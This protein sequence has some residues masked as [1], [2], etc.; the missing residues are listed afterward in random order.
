M[1]RVRV[2]RMNRDRMN[3]VTTSRGGISACSGPPNILVLYRSII[4]DFHPAEDAV[5]KTCAMRPCSSHVLVPL[6]A[7]S[8][9]AGTVLAGS[10]AL[11]PYDR[12]VA[13]NVAKLD[14]DPAKQR[15]G[16]AEALGFLRAYA[17]EQALVDRLDDPSVE[18]RRQVAMAL[19]WCGGRSAIPPLLA[20]LDDP[21]WITRQAARVSL[22]NLTGME[23]PLDAHAPPERRAAQ[24]E[25]WRG[26]WASVPAD[27]PPQDVLSLLIGPKNLASGRSVIAST[28]YK[29]PA[30]VLVDGQIGPAYWQTKN[31]EP[32]QWCIVDLGRPLQ[33]AE[34]IVHQYGPGYCMTEYELA[35]SLDNQTFEPVEHKKGTTPVALSIRFEPRKARY[36]RITS[37]G[38]EFDRY[39]TTFFE[40]EIKSE[41]EAAE[42]KFTEPVEW[43]MERGV[44]ALGVLGGD[45]ATPAILEVLGD[46]PPTAPAYRPMVRAAIRSLGR[47]REEAGFQALVALLENTMWARSAAEALGD[48][49]DARA[50]PALLAVY[51]KYA[52]QLDGQDPP[53]VPADD[54]MSF[55]SEDRMLETPYWIEYTLCRLPL[56]DPDHLKAL[57]RIAPLVMANMQGDHDTFMLYEPEVGHLVTHHLLQAC[58]LRQE[59]CEQA[60]EM[61]GQPRRVPKPDDELQWPVF[62]AYRVA[63]WLPAVATE[64]EDLPRL[65]ALLE[66]EEGWVRINAAKALAWLG[67]SRAIEP[68]G[69]LLA[70]AKAEADFGYSGTFKDEEYNDPAP[71]WREGLIRALGL[72]GAH[73][74]TDR[75]IAIL[76][77]ER[78]VLDVR[79]AA[80]EALVDLG[81]EKALEA[82]ENAAFDHSFRSIRL[83]AR[84]ALQVRGIPIKPRPLAADDRIEPLPG[85]TSP[86]AQQEMET[87]VFIKGNNSIPNTLGTV[88]QAD[89]WRATYVVTDSGPAYRP[90]GNLY[91][92]KPPRPDGQ[93]I[94]LTHFPDGYVAEPELSWDGTHVLFC[95]RGQDD[96]W[97][98]V[99]RIRVDSSGLEQLTFG[100]YHDVGPA[101]LAD[102]RIVFASSRGG[103]RD[104]YHGYPATALYVMQP[105]GTGMHPIATNI[106]RDNEPAILNDGRIVISRLE[107][108]YS[109]NKTELTLHA[110]HSDGTQ[111][112][113]LYG[114]ERRAYWRN[115]DHGLPSPADAQEAP[116]THRVLRMTQP[117]PM[118]DRRGIVVVTE[119]GLVLVGPKRDTETI[120]TPDYKERSYTTPFPLPGGR[121]LCASTL[122]VEEREKVDLGLYLLDPE[123]GNLELVYNDPAV[124][125]FEP[126]PIL[127]RRR[128]MLQPAGTQEEA[129]SGRFLCSSVFAT[130]EKDVPVRGRFVRLIEGVPVVA[131]HNTHT[132]DW[133]VWKNHGG[134]FARVLGT[135]P[136]APDGSFYVEVPADRL[137]HHQVLDSDRRVVGNQL[138]WIYP[139]PGET[140]SCVGCHENPHTTTRGND[141]IAT[142]YPPLSFLPS[143]NEFTYRA[144]A[145]FK[146]HLPPEID[147]RTRTV[148]AVN[149]LGR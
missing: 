69:R 139:R 101:Y 40:I 82:L 111:D 113:V 47:L 49:G 67:D 16:A 28:T 71:R 130:Q 39:P 104:E 143:G 60:L 99:Y 8:F 4:Y 129:Y 30:D 6:S 50:V 56:D 55:P 38:S 92:L 121:I 66:H 132:S 42:V 96:P 65:V 62:P 84:D 59:A 137:I 77:D 102:G 36:V 11:R 119:G 68:L 54:K 114:P 76:N 23:F 25:A 94:P 100:P 133:E 15:A 13:E 12:Q 118:P 103:I 35:T 9:L 97:W 125:D 14:S 10:P 45:G 51:P 33:I 142:H 122:K 128:P 98:H 80:A 19:A 127:A 18:V 58:G 107:V 17:A 52:K 135:A 123:T 73:A 87:L 140:K 108:F 105:D 110:M 136:L 1:D 116:L 75:L 147:E 7:V 78:S 27:R 46:T 3:A 148:R 88:E 81:N 145:W 91:V 24:A 117:Q 43:R 53:D 83:I 34:V 141:P 149:L 37:F 74:E 5:W 31:V 86:S 144:K 89:R 48:F 146:G 41:E 90:G 32:P 124:A 61:L 22:T 44:R 106:G 109:R 85:G 112:V 126:R 2:D 138:T 95:H 70:E 21:D 79:H 57:R 64:K 93:V 26:W 29:G 72:L 63:S 131:R 20:A 120:I 115:L 134:T